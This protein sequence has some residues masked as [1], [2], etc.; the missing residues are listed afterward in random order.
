MS[1]NQGIESAALYSPLPQAPSAS[2]ALLEAEEEANND[3]SADNEVDVLDLQ[4]RHS[5]QNLA[6]RSHSSSPSPYTDNPKDNKTIEALEMAAYEPE[7]TYGGSYG[8]SQTDIVNTAPV[9]EGR[10]GDRTAV[11]VTI[12]SL[13]TMMFGTWLLVF[14]NKPSQLGLFA[15]HPPLQTLAVTCFGLGILLLQPT[16]Q[17]KTKVQGLARH[18]LVILGIG[19]PSIIIGTIVIFVNK[20]IHEAPH[21]VTWHA[22]FGLIA[23][24]WMVI[25]MLLGGLSVWFGG[26]AFGGGM[27]AKSVWKYHRASGYLLFPLFLMTI[28]VGGNYSDWTTSKA[29][30]GVRVLLYTLAPIFALVGLWSRVRLSKMNF[31]Q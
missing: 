16:S 28:A 19:L 21:F 13:V 22:T 31:R 2:R 12:A 26:R 24:V 3:F 15:A 18:Q 5:R 29:N 14:L 9:K 23:V 27:K 1:G 20:S 8:T 11:Y 10:K 17:P 4:N 30:V 25:Q 6:Y 7:L